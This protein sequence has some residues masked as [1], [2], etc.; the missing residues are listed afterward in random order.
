MI[1][2]IISWP[3]VVTP[4]CRAQ[5]QLAANI[6]QLLEAEPGSLGVVSGGDERTMETVSWWATPAQADAAMAHLEQYLQ[7][8]GSIWWLGLTGPPRL[9]RYLGD[10]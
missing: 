7:Q 8:E 10:V 4:E 6:E 3:C 1:T 9:R 5:H 2:Q